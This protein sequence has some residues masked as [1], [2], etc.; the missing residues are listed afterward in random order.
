MTAIA[1]DFFDSDLLSSLVDDKTL[2]EAIG[3][4]AYRLVVTENVT[5]KSFLID[6]HLMDTEEQVHEKVHRLRFVDTVI[7]RGPFSDVLL[8][9][10]EE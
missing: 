9:L 6:Y 8:T 3:G 1:N 2:T 7:V 10:S 5:C 4:E